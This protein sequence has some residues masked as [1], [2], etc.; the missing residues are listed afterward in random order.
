MD[1]EVANLP[2]MAK[3]HVVVCSTHINPP[4]EMRY[5]MLLF[6]DIS[7]TLHE[8]LT[9]CRPRNIEIILQNIDLNYTS[10]NESK[11]SFLTVH[12]FLS[13]YIP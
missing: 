13:L 7:I 12:N 3:C 8:L 9:S 6:L 2:H 1:T 4:R 5:C 10:E 11:L